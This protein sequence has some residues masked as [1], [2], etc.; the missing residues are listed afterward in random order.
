MNCL[1]HEP[2]GFQCS[3]HRRRRNSYARSV[4]ASLL[5]YTLE[6]QALHVGFRPCICLRHLAK[7]SRGL[8]WRPKHIV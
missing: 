7:L 6:Q 8:T 1:S 3:F 4:T 2:P 5:L